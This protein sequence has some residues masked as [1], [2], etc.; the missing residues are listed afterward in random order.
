MGLNLR[1]RRTCIWVHPCRR[2]NKGGCSHIC[3]YINRRAYRCICKKGYRRVGRKSCRKLHPCEIRRGGCHHLCKRRGKGKFE[4]K[5]RRGYKVNPR[6]KKRCIR[7]RNPCFR[8]GG[9]QHFCIRKKKGG[10]ICKCRRGFRLHPNRRNCIRI[11]PC[12]IRRGG[13]AHICRR[14]KRGWGRY[15]LCRN[16]FK[17]WRGRH[18]RRIHPCDLRTRGGCRH[19]CRKRG[20]SFD[21]RCHLGYRLLKDKKTCGRTGPDYRNRCKSL[22]LDL[23]I[24]V[25]ASGSVKSW[26]FRKMLKII[27]SRIVED[28]NI[29]QR[30]TRVA[31]FRY[32]SRSKTK[33]IFNLN[34]YSSKRAMQRRIIATRYTKGGTYTANAMRK[35]LVS[36]KRFQRRG[37]NVKKALFVFTDGKAAESI[38]QVLAASKLWRNAGVKVYAIGIGSGIGIRGL[39]AIAGGRC[40]FKNVLRARSF[41]VLG[42]KAVELLRRMCG[43]R[44]HKC[45]FKNGGCQHICK[46]EF[47]KAVCLCKRGYRRAANKRSCIF[48]HPCVRGRNGGCSQLCKRNGKK[49]YCGCKKGYKVDKRNRKSCKKINPCFT[50][51]RGGCN[52]RCIPRGNRYYCRCYQ[53]Y[54]ILSNR[55]TC[56]KIHPCKINRG[57]C[58]HI[59]VPK[60]NNRRSCKCKK[61]YRLL[62]N[63]R[64][65]KWVHPCD[66]KGKGGCSQR[67]KKLRNAYRCLCKGG[68]RLV[69]RKSCLKKH[70]CRTRRRGGCKQRCLIKGKGFKCGC[71]RGYRLR[72]DNK[73][74]IMTC[75][76]KHA[77][78]GY[79]RRI[80]RRLLCASNG[81][82]YTSFCSWKIAQCKAVRKGIK[83]RNFRIVRN[84]RCPGPNPCKNKNGGCKRICRRVRNKAV[85]SCPRGYRLRKDRKSCWRVHPCQIRNGGCAHLCNR[86]KWRRSCGC[87]PGFKLQRNGLSCKQIHPCATKGR[88]GCQHFCRRRRGSFYCA[89]KK[90]FKLNKKNKKTCQKIHPCD[91]RTRGGCQHFCRKR[92]NNTFVCKCKN[93]YRPV[94]KRFCRKIHP[95]DTKSKGGCAHFCRKTKKSKTNRK[96]YYCSCKRGYKLIN[97][98]SCQQIHPCDTS[99]RGGCKHYC[100]KRGGSYKCTC[101][102]GYK[103]LTDNKTCKKIAPKP[104]CK[105]GTFLKKKTLAQAQAYCRKKFGGNLFME[106]TQKK[107]NLLQRSGLNYMRLWV[108]VKRNPKDIKQF[109]FVDGSPV[110]K[111]YWNKGEPNSLNERCVE[112]AKYKSWND[113]N[114]NTRLAFVCQRCPRVQKHPCDNNKGGCQHKCKKLNGNR[115]KCI[116]PKGYRLASNGKSC[117]K[118]FGEKCKALKLDLQIIV[119][120]SGSVKLHNFKKMLKMLSSSIIEDLDVGPRKTRVALFRYSSPKYFKNVFNL[121]TYSRKSDIQ[122][123]ILKVH[124]T[125]GGTYTGSAMLSAL[126]AFKKVQRRGRDVVKVLMVL[127][128]GESSTKKEKNLVKSASTLWKQA[129]VRV[130][131]IG[132]GKGISKTG[133]LS[134][135]GMN[136]K[137]VITAG[138]FDKLADK[139]VDILKGI[140]AL[141]P[142]DINNGGCQYRCRKEKNNKAVC[143]CKKGFKLA[144]NGG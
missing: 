70:P 79:C 99:R 118:R 1:N 108:G 10:R 11:H 35:A 3:R 109:I 57:G 75:R 71:I 55:R 76:R 116:C 15:C 120:A 84:G 133:L 93:G 23:Q 87:R 62:K 140:C 122:K 105:Y 20:N 123:R 26:N 22:K 124:Y 2:K 68:Y 103:L 141:H 130:Y 113:L 91:T 25:D 53:G 28:L 142:C 85:C 143:Y 92:K 80:R 51:T 65:C 13:C 101:R 6:N 121:N 48:I 54:R 139:A 98:K 40:C 46:K 78:F 7:K 50:K 17:L 82:T 60:K 5:C 31:L 81:V 14:R 69:G 95:C 134:I 39:R 83:L 36:F 74:C 24:I 59:C 33:V 100:R 18:C 9:C 88:G 73:S 107:H 138:N 30:K 34:T 112:K 58:H 102:G 32:S 144:A 61:G 77:R 4:C 129:G 132:I 106:K 19:R 115:F 41:N 49:H 131:A 16:G 137:H 119:D 12:Q 110:R 89:C 126:R 114:C 66:R 96:G 8:R 127:T 90:G 37:R 104:G 63:G 42:I 38:R 21:C 94:G 29:G 64:S 67:C 97:R 45:D 86:N 43:K 44:K 125:G 117:V 47:N 72:K 136:A 52:Q 27:S 128:D 56:V 111:S 135:A